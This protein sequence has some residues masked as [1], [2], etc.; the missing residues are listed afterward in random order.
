MQFRKH[1]IFKHHLH[2]CKMVNV[3]IPHLPRGWHQSTTPKKQKKTDLETDFL[4]GCSQTA[5]FFFKRFSKLWNTANGAW[6][7]HF[8]LPQAF[9]EQKKRGKDLQRKEKSVDL[10]I[11]N[12]HPFQGCWSC[13][14][15]FLFGNFW[16]R[17]TRWS[18]AKLQVPF[19][20]GFYLPFLCWLQDHFF[21]ETNILWHLTPRKLTRPLKSGSFLGGHSWY[22][23]GGDT[24]REIIHPRFGCKVWIENII[25]HIWEWMQQG[26]RLGPESSRQTL[27]SPII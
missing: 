15:F 12:S 18:L 4:G 27:E 20:W 7:K 23:L 11:W 3:H 17:F 24:C 9:S 1:E 8:T 10:T 2:P 14:G 21:G 13:G 5:F 22:F 16:E 25:F 6:I 19:L 26:Y